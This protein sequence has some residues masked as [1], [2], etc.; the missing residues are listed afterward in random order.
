MLREHARP[1]PRARVDADA[2]YRA[3]NSVQR[4]LIRVDADE[5]TYNLHIILRFELELALIEGTL[6]VD[7]LP[8]AWNEGMQRLLGVEVPDDA[9]GVLQD[10]HW[11]AGLFG[12][13]PTYTLG[14]LIAAQLWT[15]LQADL[16]EIEAQLGRGELA[17]LRDWL[18][19]HIHR[20]GR[21]FPPRELLHRVTGDTLRPEPF[22]DYLRAKLADAGAL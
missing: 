13:F 11:G 16:P 2:F 7:D 10:V 8:A 6:A 21:K 15:R 17:P 14:N 12:Y 4:S 20:H 3:V 22:L 5:T 1:R 9:Q 19:E 18:R